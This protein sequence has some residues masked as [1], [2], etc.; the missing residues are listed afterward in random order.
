MQ[1]QALGTTFAYLPL[2]LINVRTYCASSSL[3]SLPPTSSALPLRPR[4]LSIRIKHKNERG[5]Y[6]RTSHQLTLFHVNMNN[7]VGFNII[8][9]R[10]PI[11]NKNTDTV[12]CIQ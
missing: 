12:A 10:P 5:A 1:N 2:T 6:E 8:L 3:L 11:E 7:V 9:K 4:H